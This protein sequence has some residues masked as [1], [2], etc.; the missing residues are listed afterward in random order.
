MYSDEINPA[1]LDAFEQVFALCKI[2]VD[3]AI[4]VLSESGS[5]TINIELACKALT[6]MGLTFQRIVVPTPPPSAGPIIRSTG[7]CEALGSVPD[8][9][10]QL[11]SLIHI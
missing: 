9:V 5:R 10:E 8:V 3:E 7:A 4:T 11:L 2:S 1:W 6:R